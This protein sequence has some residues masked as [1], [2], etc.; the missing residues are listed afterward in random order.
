M[1]EDAPNLNHLW[2]GLLIEELVRGGV[3]CFCVSPGSRSTALAMAAA[4]HP[5]AKTMIHFDER[6]AAFHALGW[7][8]A[9]GRPAVLICT[10]GSAAANYWP[11]VVESSASRVPLILLTADRPPEL[12]DCRANQAID[13]S[14]LFGNYVRWSFVLPCPEAG[15]PASMVLTTAD[16]ALYR[17]RHA[18]AGPVHI[19]CMFREPLEPVPGGE[20]AVQSALQPLKRWMHSAAPWTTCYTPETS[21]SD[22]DDL[23][24]INRISD[25]RRGLL[26][27]GRLRTMEEARAA[28]LLADALRWPVFPDVL[29]GVRLGSGSDSFVH[30]FDQLLLSPRFREACA[31]EFVLHLGGAVTS[32]RLQQHLAALGPE[33]MLVTDHPLRQDPF[34]QVSHRVQAHIPAFCRWLA[35]SIRDCG[36]PAWGEQFPALSRAVSDC[37]DARVKDTGQL[38]EIFVARAVSRGRPEGTTLFLGN[39]MPIRDM[40]MYG[41]GE[42]LEGVVA[43]NR[44]ASGIDGNIA[45]VAGH[46]NALGRP[47]TAVI[48][49]LAALHDLNSLALLRDTAAPVILVLVNNDGGGIFSFLPIAEYP[50]TFERCFATPH[51]RSFADA[52]RLFGLDYTCPETQ[53]SFLEAYAGALSGTHATIIEVRTDRQ[54]NVAAHRGLQAAIS[55]LVSAWKR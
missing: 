20:A 32:K 35:P 34:H 21:L 9:S 50:E 2:A 31:P 24:V 12:L 55:T 4:R 14:K 19:D 52:A 13:Q 41:A 29:S 8:S 43:C 28:R 54:E 44:G 25:V 17:A 49:D 37:I 42:G 10:S 47:V 27:V 30:Y 5:A 40:D 1:L 18:P 11:A 45:T 46:A 39:S 23:K 48:G 38:S 26:V 6:G 53:E 36:A 16:Q 22:A 7:A 33:Y 51:G 15:L 3:D